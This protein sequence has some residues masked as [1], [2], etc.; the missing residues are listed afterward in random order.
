[1]LLVVAAIFFVGFC[2]S[3]TNGCPLVIPSSSS[4][5][6]LPSLKTINGQDDWPA[7][8]RHL[9]YSVLDPSAD[10]LTLQVGDSLAITLRS[11]PTTGYSWLAVPPAKDPSGEDEQ[12]PK[13]L[14]YRGCYYTP[15][16]RLRIG[17]GGHETWLFTATAAS[18][19]TAA[20]TRLEFMYVRPWLVGNASE[21]TDELVHRAVVQVLV[22]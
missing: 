18:P 6:E 2:A 14:T 17:G 4:S 22:L 1:M 7:N 16:A 15:T 12:Q 11:N 10:A 5:N 8:T 13:T 3:A 19:P 20:P 9:D 21:T